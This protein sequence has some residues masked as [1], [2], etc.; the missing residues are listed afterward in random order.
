ME[1]RPWPELVDRFAF[2]NPSDM[3]LT[4]TQSKLF[5]SPGHKFIHRAIGS[6]LHFL[7]LSL[8]D[9]RF[10]RDAGG[11]SSHFSSTLNNSANGPPTAKQRSKRMWRFTIKAM[12]DLGGVVHQRKMIEINR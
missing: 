10:C 9:G 11:E 5:F 8:G 4:F 2:S 12:G 3:T 7:P 1:L 6:F